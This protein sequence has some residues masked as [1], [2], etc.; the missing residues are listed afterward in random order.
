[1][2]YQKI[3]LPTVNKEIGHLEHKT[4]QNVNLVVCFNECVKLQAIR[5]KKQ[6]KYSYR[7]SELGPANMK[8]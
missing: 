7:F 4:P 1:M 3:M 8:N 5:K 6:Q 2:S